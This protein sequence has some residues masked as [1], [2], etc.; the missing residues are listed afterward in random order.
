[1]QLAV[2]PRT[3]GTLNVFYTLK[4]I[5]EKDEIIIYNKYFS[6]NQI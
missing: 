1:M 5:K 6:P 3:P 4:L 2:L